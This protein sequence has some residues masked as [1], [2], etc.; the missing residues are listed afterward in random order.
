MTKFFRAIANFIYDLCIDG[1]VVVSF[2]APIAS[3]SFTLAK[4]LNLPLAGIHELSYAWGLLPI[5]VWFFVAYVRRRAAKSRTAKLAKLHEFY[6]R[7]NAITARNDVTARNFQ[8]YVAEADAW[9]AE[10]TKWIS[11]NLGPAARARFLDQTNHLPLNYP[12]INQEHSNLLLNVNRWQ[13]NITRLIE[14]DAWDRAG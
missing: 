2:A 11:D 3:L 13:A 4:F 1:Y 10:A 14:R 8:A 7:A 12:G 5:T 9:L 6:I